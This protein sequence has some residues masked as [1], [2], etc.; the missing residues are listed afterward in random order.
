MFYV[1]TALFPEHEQEF[2]YF[3][4]SDFIIPWGKPMIKTWF[5][6][7]DHYLWH[8]EVVCFWVPCS[9]IKSIAAKAITT[10][11]FFTN[12]KVRFSGTWKT[13]KRFSTQVAKSNLQTCKITP[14][15]E[16]QT[17]NNGSLRWKA[18]GLNN[19]RLELSLQLLRNDTKV[20]T[21]SVFSAIPKENYRIM[22]TLRVCSLV[23]S[24][25]HSKTKTFLFES[26]FEL[27]VGVLYAVITRLMLKCL[28]SGWEW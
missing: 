11:N 4:A 14:W 17:K 20:F 12:V 9:S 25:L 13:W 24:D 26:S 2:C 5:S 16:N 19:Y 8:R 18:T 3:H 6:H 1:K 10:Q 21:Q 27:C 7:T 23:D 15:L 28:W 22:K